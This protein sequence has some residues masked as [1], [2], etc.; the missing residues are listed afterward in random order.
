GPGSCI[1]DGQHATAKWENIYGY[2]FLSLEVNLYCCV[3]TPYLM[4]QGAHL[5][6]VVSHILNIASCKPDGTRYEGPGE[7]HE[8]LCKGPDTLLFPIFEVNLHSCKV[9]ATAI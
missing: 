3:P 8:G 7:R 6:Q 2:A 4:V 9:A 5:S 1:S